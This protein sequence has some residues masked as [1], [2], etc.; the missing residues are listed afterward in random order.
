[1]AQGFSAGKMDLLKKLLA[2]KGL[3][4]LDQ[5]T[6]QPRRTDLPCP[7]SYSQ[8]RLWFLDKFDSESK[9]FNIPAMICLR[10]N[11]NRNW[12]INAINETVK[13]HEVLRT[14]FI[15]DGEE[16]L[17]IVHENLEIS[18]PFQ[19]ISDLSKAEKEV[20]VMQSVREAAMRE[21]SL[22]SLPLI[23]F[24]LL[25]LETDEHILVLVMHHIISDG[26]S[27]GVLIN[28][29]SEIYAAFE[30]N[31]APNLPRLSIQYPD[32]AVWQRENIESGKLERQV[33]YWTEK[34]SGRLPILELPT[35]K[36]RPNIQF[37]QGASFKIEFDE[38]LASSVKSL[39]K[40]NDSTLFV[41]LLAGYK[42]LLH[43]YSRQYEII[44]GTSVAGRNYAETEPLIG[45]FLNSIV[46][47]SFI[48]KNESFAE[49]L[50]HLRKT[51]LE[52]FENQDAPIELLIE[53]LKLE[54]NPGRSPLFQ[55]LFVMQNN[56][57][58]ALRIGSLDAEIIEVENNSAKFDISVSAEEK[59]GKITLDFEYDTNLFES[60]TIERFAAH[61]RNLMRE[62]A[63]NDSLVID[64]INLIDEAETARIKTISQG[65]EMPKTNQ[66]VH[67]II[68]TKA[69]QTPDAI[70]VRFEETT[71]TYKELNAQA[72]CLARILT[73][74]GFKIE[75]KIGLYFE[76]SPEMIIAL[77]AILK[78]GA[79]YV[80]LDPRYPSERLSFIAEDA[81]LSAV[82][83][84]RAVK[85]NLTVDCPFLVWED[86]AESLE[87][88]S[89][90]ELETDLDGENLAYLIYTS[91]STGK[92]KAVMSRHAGLSNY[93]Q[94]AVKEFGL[95]ESDKVLQF[96]SVSFDTSAEEIFSCLM[97][98]AT[99]VL[100]NE[101]M[102]STMTEFVRRCG[103]WEIT[104]LDLP[105]VFWHLLVD[106]FDAE[107][108]NLPESLRLVIIGGE[109]AKSSAVRRWT[110]KTPKNIALHNT[111]GPTE[112]TIVATSEQFMDSEAE[113]SPEFGIGKPVGNT[114][115][116]V[117]DE[118][119]QILPHG[120]IGELFIGGD[121]LARG[122]LNQAALTAEKFVP[123]PF[124]EGKRLYRTGDLVRWNQF[125]KLEFIGRA[126]RQVK[127]RGYRVE[128]GEIETVLVQNEQIKQAAVLATGETLTAY[129]VKAN[130]EIEVESLRE[131][132]RQKL[133][134]Y[135][136]PQKFVEVEK[137]P[138]NANGK[139]DEAVLKQSDATELRISN[140]VERELP[141]GEIEVR[142]AQLWAE[143]LGIGEIGRRENFFE[144]GG[145]SL[146]VTKVLARLREKFEIE[147]PLRDFFEN[148]TVAATAS[149]I[150]NAESRGTG[151]IPKI[152]KAP[153]NA[154]IPLSFPQERIWFLCQ[155]D[156]TNVAYNVPRAVRITGNLDKNLVEKAFTEIFRRHE[157]LRT[158]FHTIDAQPV[159][160]VNEPQ[161]VKIKS[162]D[163]RHLAPEH[164]KFE[165]DEYIETEGNRI[166]NLAEL[167]LLR[168]S[169]LRIAEKEHILVLVEHHLLHDGWTQGVLINDFI[170]VYE[171]FAEGKSSPLAPL[172]IQYGDFAY[173]QRNWL[174]GENLERL[175]AYWQKTLR[176]A[177]E[178]LQL[179]TTFPRP[180]MRSSRGGEIILE[181]DEQLAKDLRELSRQ[182][183]ATLY[184][185]M[186]AV[187]KTLFYRYSG[188][189]DIV[190]GSGVANR[191]L[192]EI[193]DLIGMVVNTIPLRT[194]FSGNFSFTE[195]LEKI[196]AVALNA[197]AH[198]DVPFEKLVEVLKPNRSLA[199]TPVFQVL[200]S[201]LNTPM[202]TMRLA[203][204]NFE[205][206]DA[207][208]KSSKF[209]LNIIVVSPE[210]Q[211]RGLQ[212]QIETSRLTILLEYSTD[213]YDEQTVK[214]L[215]AHYEELLRSIIA[216][217]EKKLSELNF[218]SE[219]EKFALATAQNGKTKPLPDNLNLVQ[220]FEQQV[221]ETPEKI[222]LEFGAEKLTYAELN[223]RANRLAHYLRNSGAKN[224]T[225]IGVCVNRSPEMLI[226]LLAILKTG[227][228]YIPLDPIYPRERIEYALHDAQARILI[229]EKSHA[230]TFE[231][232][233][234]ELVVIDEIAFENLPNENTTVE[235]D[236]ENL[237]Y[238]IYTSGSTGK[239]KGVQ[240]T[241]R[242]VNNF[243][244]AMRETL[245]IT[246]DDCL[247]AVTTVSFDI[248]VL[249]LFLPLTIGAK[250]VLASHAQA[251]N[252]H[253]LSK[254]LHESKASIC[255]ATPAT[256][257]MLTATG[258]MQK[259]LKIL[260]GGEALASDLALE[261]KK[262]GELWNMYGPTETTIYS[263]GVNL[264]KKTG[265]ISL[266]SPIA[267]T[268]FYIVDE[269]FNLVPQGI[270]G[271]LL[272]GGAGLA[273]GYVNQSALTAERFVPD[274]FSERG[275]AR[276]YRTGD[277]VKL[278]QNEEIVFLGRIDNQVK[279]RGYRIE[280]GEIEAVMSAIDCVKQA[281]VSVYET[282]QD[283]RLIA[284][285]TAEKDSQNLTEDFIRQTL[286]KE[287]PVYMIPSA[288]V[289]LDAFPLTPN[290]KIDRRAL[291][292]PSEITRRAENKSE[293]Q[294]ATE[295]S[296][297]KI[298][299]DLLEFDEIYRADNFFAIGGHSLLATQMIS[300]I[301]EN[302]CADL[303]LR[304]IFEKT[305]LAEI[306]AEIDTF[307]ADERSD[308]AP[309]TKRE[310]NKH[311]PL[312]YSQKRL[313]FL[314]RLNPESPA[315]NIPFAVKLKGN[316][317]IDELE[318]ALRETVNRHEILRSS[319][320]EIDGDPVQ[321]VN[322]NLFKLLQRDFTNL[323]AEN[324][325][326]KAL[327][328]ARNDADR[329]FDLAS[330]EIFRATLL[331]LSDSE[332]M[333]LLNT[334]HIAADG[335][336][337]G[338]IVREVSALYKAY[339][340][341]QAANLPELKFQYADYAVW[342]FD[343]L[344]GEIWEKQMSY[345]R[346][347]LA[348]APPVLN[349][350]TD[351]SRPAV[352]SGKGASA[353]FTLNSQF[354][355]KL[356]NFGAENG[357]TLFMTF[358][359]ATQTLL[360]RWSGQRD[361]LIGSPIAGRARAE[362][363]NLVGC[364]I[365][366]LVLR[367]KV[368]GNLSFADFLKRTKETTLTAY[369][370]QDVPFEAIIEELQPERSLSYSPIFQVLLAFQ[371]APESR[372]ALSDVELELLPLENTHS[373]GDLHFNFTENGTEIFCLIEYNTD[374]FVTATI[375][376]M[377]QHLQNLLENI[378]RDSK[379]NLDLIDL[380]DETERQFLTDKL[381]RTENSLSA[382]T[383]IELIKNQANENPDAVALKFGEKTFSYREFN[384]T[385]E[386]VAKKLVKAGIK[387]G[388]VIGICA[389][390][391][392]ET[393]I[394][395]M[396]ILK[397]GATYLPLDTDYPAERLAF[398]VC[399]SG[400]KIVLGRDTFQAKFTELESE[401]IGFD[402][403]FAESSDE[404]ESIV[405]PPIS[406]EDAA[407]IIYTSGSTG[408]PKGVIATHKSVVRLTQADYI[409]SQASDV[410][411]QFAPLAFDASTFEI[412]TCLAHGAT[413]VIAPPEK[414]STAELG[415]LIS[416]EKITILWLTAGLF[417]LMVSE[418]LEDLKN[419]RYLLAGGDILAPESVHKAM[420][421]LPLCQIVNGYGPTEATTFA[422]CNLI[423]NADFT[424]SSVPI[425]VP[426]SNTQGYV[427]D[428]QMQIVPQGVVGEL[429]L[430][431][432]GLARGYLNQ[433]TLT[434]ER[435]VP[436]PFGEGARLYRTG[437]L[438]RWNQSEKLEFIGRADRQVKV[439]GYR[440]ELGEIET[441]LEQ[442][443]QIKQAVV[444]AD[445]ETLT[446]Y[447]IKNSQEFD[448]SKLQNEIA[449]RLPEYLRPQKFVEVGEIPLTA[450]GKVDGKKLKESAG[451]QLRSA[452][453]E[454]ELPLSET[455][456]QIAQIWTE[457]LKIEQIGRRENFFELGGHSLLA[458]RILSRIKDSTGIDVPLRDVFAAPTIES[459]AIVVEKMREQTPEK[460]AS[461]IKRVE[462]KIFIAGGENQ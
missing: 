338:I 318:N 406:G 373:R 195:L 63:E 12:L 376:R 271:E 276:L 414:L 19:D 253:Q 104:I 252:A 334:H 238:V 305:S 247:L 323:P 92:P 260:C 82:L 393:I 361:I 64:A 49:F 302:F 96:A 192:R 44:V 164:Q 78:A 2:E 98:G 295:K 245:E 67:Q 440:M 77:L 417:H 144:L 119:M 13:R 171:A 107:N 265:E 299:R 20:F 352:Q 255:Q 139:I 397:A 296:L 187:F 254:L 203:G 285:L 200:I 165:I 349:L 439:R 6:P 423:E 128:L 387:R 310:I 314:H 85:H 309:I 340:E 8:Q 282:A 354:V 156:P 180:A 319:F 437:D 411:L 89:D 326:E 226:V 142:I 208:N 135:L 270:A 166:F 289:F 249:E 163:L 244:L 130:T 251:S 162:L 58:F 86:L 347:Q 172:K 41:T 113:I 132:L 331:R 287:L 209:D 420:A 382:E 184:M 284:Y 358:L 416:D 313:W 315:Y 75:D 274:P 342:Q 83:M 450:N 149:A 214:R 455:E 262:R 458:A 34:L 5:N 293:P 346:K 137:I 109:K 327:N 332:N 32:Y 374:I 152:E 424:N 133:P 54:R 185:T 277:Q 114:N 385:A 459:L 225:R 381:N 175:L 427:L 229:T 70:A 176:G 243:L 80:P 87:S 22:A 263:S 269:N 72:N 348:D 11:L 57:T 250:I 434:A 4:T 179:P 196:R 359:A 300:R 351:F 111:Y 330:G 328:Y 451:N 297:A 124:D 31:R 1:M 126:D 350:P 174:K 201:F 362:L 372:A 182:H 56:P 266:G 122:Y 123:N 158:T 60:A 198:Q 9:A 74:N 419:L 337:M 242:A 389:E 322:E 46:L 153:E 88:V 454:R 264:S 148:P 68:A 431:G 246:A 204:L 157:I 341:K 355:S 317:D 112:A 275:G 194:E 366:M 357:A 232:A 71:L 368:D 140:T 394:S 441:V 178:L 329:P 65:V 191:N 230:P 292:L 224:E 221:L 227:A 42:A 7:L 101:A 210:D 29:I 154:V 183:N 412:W 47:R 173:W 220:M 181:L 115:A 408:Q 188:Q 396:A 403:L 371:T 415:K 23:K 364:F 170:K 239:P 237:A 442:N 117:L 100:R 141:I 384:E 312:S 105:T 399:D 383:I 345:W 360:Y 390:R 311:A 50:K 10:G 106:S 443:E 324:R 168:L 268:Q 45:F 367:A 436:D 261:I 365:N 278:A 395:L 447:L 59:D 43:R 93:A 421:N 127:V 333:L 273:R 69:I 28:E 240:I 37:H 25:K 134:E 413:L 118:Q 110:Q 177:P 17:Q 125:E 316:L 108:V 189:T 462:R 375:R 84:H 116:Y 36:P 138:L 386:I 461:P 433:A 206:L 15:S 457:L 448:L 370:N 150:E 61:Y 444:L 272:I 429:Y 91:G 207:H 234:F 425:G 205:S 21:F 460:T 267:N 259:D 281:V 400:A 136:R 218:L 231:K 223:E 428:K 398:I 290:G 280:L 145:H 94:H 235:I 186:F 343:N 339:T 283:K 97:A 291:S 435:F 38:T 410:F 197:Y 199:Y 18:L 388:S 131:E 446:A 286:E 402:A 449:A 320:D 48:S 321:I 453:V 147:I 76:R 129:L 380:I 146:L 16:P 377:K 99:L 39:A 432:G 55:T 167:P 66:T 121:G 363:E 81:K 95:S 212:S 304:T 456:M 307:A 14:A 256:W 213:L 279:L 155:L 409:S 53:R 228:A 103:E 73:E 344:R 211:N 219:S 24:S 160:K 301:R 438:V 236:A 52:A 306:A 102:L 308:I 222:A 353:T 3:E 391:S 215:L 294:T 430:G 190:V 161:T 298:W 404:L 257:R 151:N 30:E 369:E 27:I 258:W 248:A 336:S 335:W 62:V 26:W 378:C 159:Q 233:D 79:V 120:V 445:G 90:K 193:E 143:L 35:D 405:L 452:A 325:L 426:I 392:A 356:K 379:Q 401:F 216:A 303:P 407:Y 169:L 241:H 217:P 418:R 51:S 40:N 422:C 288:F 202:R 33:G